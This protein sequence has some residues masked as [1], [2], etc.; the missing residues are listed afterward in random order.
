MNHHQATW[1]NLNLS[2]HNRPAEKQSP[3]AI[4]LT[5]ESATAPIDGKPEATRNL[6][7]S[8]PDLIVIQAK[9]Q[10]RSEPNLFDFKAG[11]AL[12]PLQQDSVC[13]SRETDEAVGFPSFT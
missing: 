12:Q 7:A 9:S 8:K 1:A 4:S 2:H 13:K 5:I 10:C 6:I 11:T 3:P